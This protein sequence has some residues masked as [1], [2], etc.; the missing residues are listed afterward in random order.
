MERMLNHLW[1]P[2]RMAYIQD[3]KKEEGCVFCKAL[4]SQNDAANLVVYRGQ[5]VF[6]ILNRY[7]YTSGHLMVVP[8]THAASLQELTPE[9]RSELMELA[10]KSL[11]VLNDGYHPQGYNF[12]MN[13][14]E[15]AGAGIADHVHMH[16]VPRWSGD[17]N[18][19]S[20][21]AATRVLP[22]ALED[23]Y[24]KVIKAWENS[25]H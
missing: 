20:T 25:D 16:I 9:I 21:T 13:L 2:W 22:E 24:L 12:G 19:M 18:F 17:T 7:P 6:V 1:S 15:I 4:T 23:T 11:R 3:D 14:G 5:G 8:N 10:V